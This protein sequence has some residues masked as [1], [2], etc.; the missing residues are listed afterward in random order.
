MLKTERGIY[1]FP[2]SDGLYHRFSMRAQAGQPNPMNTPATIHSR[3]DRDVLV[4]AANGKQ[5]H[6]SPATPSPEQKRSFG[7][8]CRLS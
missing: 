2:M 8:N 6:R 3:H 5:K 1:F 7:L 4:V